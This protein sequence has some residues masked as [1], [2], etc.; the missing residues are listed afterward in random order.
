MESD[1][2]QDFVPVELVLLP[3]DAGEDAP[4]VDPEQYGQLRLPLS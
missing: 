4:Q 1:G 3:D 2:E